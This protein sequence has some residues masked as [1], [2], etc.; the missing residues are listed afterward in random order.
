MAWPTVTIVTTD[1]DAG[2]DSAANARAQIKQMADNVNDIKD[3]KGQNNGV[4]ELDSGGKVPAGQLPV[5]S[6]TLGGTG[7]SGY[8]AGDILYALNSTTLSKLPAGSSGFVLT[9]NG[10]GAAPSWQNTAAGFPSGTR[11]L[12]QQTSAPPGWTKETN[13]AYND[14]SMRIVTGSVSSGGADDFTAV[15]GVSKSTGAFTLTTSHI[16]SHAHPYTN[17]TV[18]SGLTDVNAFS[19]ATARS[20]PTVNGGT[21]GASG[22]GGSHSHTL[23]MD[24]KYRDVI[25]AEKN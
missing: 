8:T 10:A 4:A 6:A 15:F 7:Q 23:Q 1:M 13:S 24:I 22:S 17:P 18:G 19:G 9:S 25:I 5:I 21:T 20:T 2:T 11:M 14:V 12:F 16:P 3:A